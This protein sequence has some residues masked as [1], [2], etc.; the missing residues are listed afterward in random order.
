MNNKM[1][2]RCGSNVKNN[3]SQFCKNCFKKLFEKKVLNFL[4]N[5]PYKRLYVFS[6][7]NEDVFKY[8]LSKYFKKV[9]YAIKGNKTSNDAFIISKELFS[10]KVLFDLSNISEFN[11]EYFLENISQD[12]P[13]KTKD[14]D[15]NYD[16]PFKKIS[17]REIEFYYNHYYE[18]NYNE[19]I[20][21]IISKKVIRTNVEDNEIFNEIIKKGYLKLIENIIKENEEVIYSFMSYF[22]ELKID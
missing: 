11:E 17:K 5:S 9:K 16:S 15:F 12:K 19:D 18:K 10:A 21:N 14:Y 7:I 22:N 4:Y 3:T 20:F 8:I 6:D 13:I 2:K 1:C